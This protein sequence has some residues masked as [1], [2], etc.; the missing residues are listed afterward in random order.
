MK[1]ASWQMQSV[2]V[3]GGFI[4]LSLLLTPDIAAAVNISAGSVNA[5]AGQSATVP[6]AM[7]LG[8]ANVEFFGVTFTV[9]PQE[10]ASAITGKLTY[11]AAT[12]PGAPQLTS[13]S[14]PGT[15]AMG[16]VTGISP[17]LTG[18]LVVGTLTVPIPAGATGS[19]EVQLSRISAGDS[20]GNRITLLGQ[21]G[22]ITVR[23]KPTPTNTQMPTLTPTKTPT[24]TP[25]NTPT[26]TPTQTPTRTPTPTPPC[27]GA[28]DGDGA[29]TVSNLLAMVNIALGNANVSTCR[30]GDAN[31]DSKVTVDEIL[32]AVNNALHGCL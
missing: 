26:H 23:P 5:A 3:L 1:H 29:V 2:R 30:A 17:P 18:T 7:N 12:P 6:I 8:S 32:S 13:N 24:S 16:Y 31:H 15:F 10:G 4:A 9:V 14:V 22:M 28:C 11:Q 21:N 25:T 20:S 27:V 19:Y